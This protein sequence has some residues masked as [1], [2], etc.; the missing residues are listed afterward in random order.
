MT[1]YNQCTVTTKKG[2]TIT[3]TC[4]LNQWSVK[5]NDLERVTNEA[6]HYFN[7]Y[8]RDGEYSSIIGGPSVIDVI[9]EMG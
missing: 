9:R 1:E 6:R 4:K 5:G 8:K 3:I 2:D 7:Q